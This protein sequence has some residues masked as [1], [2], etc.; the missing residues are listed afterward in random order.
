MK[1]KHK[2]YLDDVRTPIDNSWKVVRNYNQFKNAIMLLEIENIELIS[3]DH[4]LGTEAMEE[5]FKNVV[6]NFVL[7]YDN[8]MNEQTGLDCAKY[9]VEKCMDNNIKPPII[10][11]HSANPIG[12]ANIMGYINNFLKNIGEPQTCIRKDIPHTVDKNLMR[13]Y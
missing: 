2:I 6:P 7:N 13:K 10:H 12:A 8:I 1:K 4:D 11:V 9:I 5:Y 3:L